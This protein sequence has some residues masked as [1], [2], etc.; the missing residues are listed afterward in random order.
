MSVRKT[1]HPLFID[2]INLVHTL[3]AHLAQ[4]LML[5][6]LTFDLGH[7]FTKGTYTGKVRLRLK[8]SSSNVYV[9]WLQLKAQVFKSDHFLSVSLFVCPSVY[10]LFRFLSFTSQEP[11]DQVQLNL[12]NISLGEVDSNLLKGYALMQVEMIKGINEGKSFKIL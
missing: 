9:P 3:L 5:D 6:D 7:T 8:V 1:L 12:A 2:Y 4:R 10:K 11:L